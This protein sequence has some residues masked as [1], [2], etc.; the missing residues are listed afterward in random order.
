MP[1]SPNASS[2]PPLA[3]PVRCGRYCL[4]CLVLRGISMSLRPPF[5]AA[6]R[7]RRPARRE[8]RP[9]QRTARRWRRDGRRCASCHYRAGARRAGRGGLLGGSRGRSRGLL[10]VGAAT[11]G[12]ALVATTARALGTRAAAAGA[13]T[14]RGGLLG[15]ELLGGDVALVDPHLHADA[16]EGGAGLVEAVVDVRAEGVQRHAPLAV[17]LVAA[18]LG[19]AEAAGDGHSDALRA[20]ALRG[21]H[22]LAH[23]TAEGD[24]GGELLGD[25]LSD[26]LGVGLGVL[27]LEDVQLDLLAGELL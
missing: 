4:R 22:A 26:Q 10:G 2:V 14:L 3:M 15:R 5:R 7:A 12:V 19:A 6:V 11:G 17:E 27:D 25:A 1:Y 9:E 20:G 16:A 13:G 24:S 23:R 8:P 18:H 21:L